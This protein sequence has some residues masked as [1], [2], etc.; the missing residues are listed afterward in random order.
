MKSK[1]ECLSY[2]LIKN[3]KKNLND[4]FGIYHIKYPSYIMLI[5]YILI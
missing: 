4:K 2:L 1:F 3:N 5:D